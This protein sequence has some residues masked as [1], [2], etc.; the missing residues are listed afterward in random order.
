MYQSKC[1]LPGLRLQELQRKTQQKT[2]KKVVVLIHEYDKSMMDVPIEPEV[3]EENRRIMGDF[4]RCPQT[5][6]L[7]V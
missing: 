4:L 2:R 3:A 6:G 7:Q 1:R 5:D